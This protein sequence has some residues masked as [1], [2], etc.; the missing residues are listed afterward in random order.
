MAVKEIKIRS[1]IPIYAVGATWLLYSL[2]FPLYRLLDFVIAALVSALVYVILYILVPDKRVQVTESDFAKS[3]DSLADETVA[4]G[5]VM[6]NELKALAGQ[7]NHQGLRQTVDE[8][9]RIGA[10]IYDYVAKHPKSAAQLRKFNSYYFPETL[11]LLKAYT[12]ID[13]YDTVGKSVRDTKT[14]IADAMLLMRN[15]FAN[16]LDALLHDK[17]FDVRTDIKVLDALLA[18]EGLS[19]EISSET[20]GKE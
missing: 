17:A 19:K 16:Q 8:L 15:A 6:L 1:N 12:E 2:V 4:Q 7:L 10:S 18:E 14:K 5:E 13:D 9:G 20:E 11:K 3:G